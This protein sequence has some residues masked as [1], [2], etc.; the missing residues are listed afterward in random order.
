MPTGLYLPEDPDYTVV[1]SVRDSVRF[2]HYCLEPSNHGKWAARS[3]AVGPDGRPV[4]GHPLAN[5]EGPGGEANA[6]GGALTLYRWAR[7]DQNHILEK[8]ALG[9]LD[10][11]LDDG[12][13]TGDG[14]VRPWRDMETGKFRLNAAGEEGWFSPAEQARIGLQM[15]WWADALPVADGR[16]E[17]LRGLAARLGEIVRNNLADKAEWLPARRSVRGDSEGTAGAEGLYAAWLFM[18]LAERGL[19]DW[20]EPGREL[21]DSFMRRGGIY[22]WEGDGDSSRGRAL[23]IRV[24][25]RA[26]ERY[27]DPSFGDFALREILPPLEARLLRA[28]LSGLPTMG[29]VT[30]GPDPSVALMADAAEC[31]LACQEAS[32]A[33]GDRNQLCEGVTMLRAIARVHH[34]QSEPHGF[35]AA[36]LELSNEPVAGVRAD[37]VTSPLY[38]NLLHVNAA[39]HYLSRRVI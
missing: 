2:A 10:H 14:P 22:G 15:G 30:A 23:V 12:F 37:S 32:E 20:L 26:A 24:L 13:V 38:S 8:V 16:T 3:S 21:L 4:A 35:L 29:L 33:S 17:R 11:V 36:G 6:L 5:L 7:F 9:L 39:L 19:G 28:D 1:D 34:L 18:E 25:R 27:R 31:S